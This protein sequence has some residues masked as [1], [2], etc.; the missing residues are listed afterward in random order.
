MSTKHYIELKIEQHEAPLKNEG[1][2]QCFTN[3]AVRLCYSSYKSGNK[4]RMR[5][6]DLRIQQPYTAITKVRQN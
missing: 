3:A 5:K 4:S 2:C 6:S 1:D